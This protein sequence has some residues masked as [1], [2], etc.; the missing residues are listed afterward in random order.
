MIPYFKP[1]T[2]YPPFRASQAVQFLIGDPHRSRFLPWETGS[3][4]GLHAPTTSSLTVPI[5]IA[6]PLLLPRPIPQPRQNVLLPKT[7]SSA[8]AHRSLTCSLTT[9]YLLTPHPE[10]SRPIA[11]GPVLI[12]SSSRRGIKEGGPSHPP[13]ICNAEKHAH[14]PLVERYPTL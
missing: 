2:I 12:R 3:M 11:I 13:K 1:L 10:A 9:L 6:P 7:N 5:L 14:S 4:Q 8:P